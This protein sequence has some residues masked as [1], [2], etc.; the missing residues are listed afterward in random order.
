MWRT[1]L[2]VIAAALLGSVLAT[3]LCSSWL[4][5]RE[6]LPASST[7]DDLRIL[8]IISLTAAL[9]TVPGALL[10]A[11]VE[12]ALSNR[13]RPERA[14]DVALVA[15]GALTGAAMLGVLSDPE[16]VLDS[17]LTGG[18]YG[19]TTA[20]LFCIFQHQLGSRRDAD[21]YLH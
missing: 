1:A 11:A 6:I 5:F 14:L 4:A 19:L 21:F 12:F 15:L 2:S 10:L 13:L 9:F 7:V 18:F 8:L 16:A 17:A 3:I 20:L